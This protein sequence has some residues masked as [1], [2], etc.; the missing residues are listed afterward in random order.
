MRMFTYSHLSHLQPQIRQPARLVL[1][2]L[3]LC[4][5]VRVRYIAHAIKGLSKHARLADAVCA[6]T[7]DLQDYLSAKE[8]RR[9]QPGL[10]LLSFRLTVSLPSA[11]PARLMGPRAISGDDSAWLHKD[12]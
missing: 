10:K 7:A 2:H 4:K 1:L 5:D 6:A 11:M 9:G 3:Y 12:P 8:R